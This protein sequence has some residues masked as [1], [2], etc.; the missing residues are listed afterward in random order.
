MDKGALVAI[1]IFC[2]LLFGGLLYLFIQPTDLN[3][4]IALAVMLMIN[5]GIM[6][7][8]LWASEY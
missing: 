4:W 7:G 8:F 1:T 5:P 3:G 2:I 6:L